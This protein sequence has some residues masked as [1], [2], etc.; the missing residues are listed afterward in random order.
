MNSWYLI[1]SHIHGTYLN[2]FYSLKMCWISLLDAK[3][4]LHFFTGTFQISLSFVTYIGLYVSKLLMISSNGGIKFS[5]TVDMCYLVASWKL[6]VK[7]LFKASFL[8]W[9]QNASYR[10]N[11]FRMKEYSVFFQALI[12]SIWRFCLSYIDKIVLIVF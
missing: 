12:T 1:A 4:F 11:R 7:S 3:G 10:K 5:I 6:F 2:M 9:M 8:N